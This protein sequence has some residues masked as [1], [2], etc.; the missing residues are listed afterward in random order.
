MFKLFPVLH[1]IVNYLCTVVASKFVYLASIFIYSRF[2]SVYDYGVFNILL[3]YLWIFVIGMSLN[4]Y[5][6]SSRYIYREKA[7]IG[8]F[9]GTSI[10]IIGVVYTFVAT[11]FVV[12]LKDISLYLALPAPGVLLLMVIV[13]GQIAESL[14]TQMAVIRQHSAL[15]LRV[16]AIKSLAT[17]VLSLGL[18]FIIKSEKYYAFFVAEA[19]VSLI[20]TWYVWHS[21]KNSIRWNPTIDHLRFILMYSLPLIPYMLGLT[22]LSH[23]DRIMIDHYFGKQTAGLYSLIY[24]IGLLL[25][26]I[27]TAVL[28]AFNPAF[29]KSMNVGNVNEVQRESSSLFSIAAVGAVILALFGE[30]FISLIAPE[31]YAAAFDLISVLAIAGLCSIIFQIWVRIIFY[32]HRTFF[33]SVIIIV[34]TIVNIGL[35]YWLLPIYGYKIAAVITGVSYLFMSLLCI[36]TVNYAINILKVNITLE[37]T[38]ILVLVTMVAFLHYIKMSL[39]VDLSL[40]IIFVALFAW[41]LKDRIISLLITRNTPSVEP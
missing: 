32:A 38:L 28:N 11:I 3:S 20:F 6:A 31:K 27:M 30:P 1:H 23:F 21:L 37:L 18:M 39:W 26:M 7:D 4:L 25:P 24:N 9:L 22:L 33:A 14:F 12:Y 2:F 8:G 36:A 5:T 29:Y 41:W 13:L 16:I 10:I 15:L 35:N 34:T 17:F 19:I 40:R